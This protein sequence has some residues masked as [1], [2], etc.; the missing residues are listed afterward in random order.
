VTA[1]SGLVEAPPVV[2]RTRSSHAAARP[3]PVAPG[4]P[5]LGGDRPGRSRLHALTL[6]VLVAGLA[7]SALGA[8]SASAAHRSTE[9]RLLDRQTA[10]AA[11]VLGGS[12]ATVTGVLAAAAEVA[13][14]SGGDPGLFEQIIG[15]RVVEG[16]SFVNASLWDLEARSAAPAPVVHL[17]VPPAIEAAGPGEVA[18]MLEGAAATPGIHIVGLYL[19]PAPRLAYVYTPEVRPARWAVYVEAPLPP[20]RRNV[21]QS[22]EAFA[23]LDFA[24]YV[25]AT[26][27]DAALLWSSTPDLPIDGRRSVVDVPF[28][29]AGLRLAMTPN[30]TLASSLS[31]LLPWLVAALGTLISLVGAGLTE[32]LL[33]GRDRA[34]RLAADN[35]RLFDAQR[36]VA[37]TLQR[38][39]LPDAVPVVPHAQIAVRYWPAGDGLEVGGDVYDVFPLGRGRWGIMIGDVCGK[40]VQAAALTG[41]TRH[42]IRAAARHVDSP[43]EVLRWVHDAVRASGRETFC[44][45]CFAVLDV[46]QPGPALVT[47]SLGGHPP[48]LLCRA[49]GE[50]EPVGEFGTVLGLVRPELHD[51]SFSMAAGDVLVLYTDGL[52]DAPGEGGVLVEDVV[53]AHRAAPQRSADGVA[54][55]IAELLSERR[56]LGSGDDTALLV[57]RVLPDP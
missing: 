55:R 1:R 34:V 15:P 16:T 46:A 19:E 45:A 47:L 48:P 31:Q 3:V 49:G 23:D 17:G 25:G 41:L 2:R 28:G 57:L 39:L 37:T 12:V 43:S 54:D 38:S 29:D 8:A 6:V 35:Q 10:Q 11:A 30:R 24:L 27:D 7:L 4:A 14:A 20:D 18:A 9:R 32:R 33:R 56:P 40:G 51:V 53:A 26:E 52:T 13:G 50:A 42:T 5:A 44:T 22:G 36:E 21:Q